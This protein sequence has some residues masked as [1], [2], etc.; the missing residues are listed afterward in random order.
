LK[1]DA[2][3]AA[4]AILSVLNRARRIDKEFADAIRE[5][6]DLIIAEVLQWRDSG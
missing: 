5:P 4:H 1:D 3:L 6:V 2:L